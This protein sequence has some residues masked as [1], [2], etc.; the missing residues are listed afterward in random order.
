MDYAPTEKIDGERQGK[1]MGDLEEQGEL[2]IQVKSPL[3]RP[4]VESK[5]DG[6][7]KTIK[8]IQ[9]ERSQNQN[10]ED[11][12][13]LQE[14]EGSEKGSERRTGIRRSLAS[15]MISP[16]QIPRWLEAA[17]GTQLVRP[18][19]L[20]IRPDLITADLS[21]APLASMNAPGLL[22]RPDSFPKSSFLNSL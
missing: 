7:S 10:A 1:E 6:T 16:R 21:T 19:P 20:N 4:T 5:L 14:G 11:S 9:R 17:L 18:T 22:I 2:Q 3:Q 8:E 12:N 15:Q 13:P